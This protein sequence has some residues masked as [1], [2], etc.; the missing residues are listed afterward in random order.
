[1]TCTR[2]SDRSAARAC[3]CLCRL[4]LSMREILWRLCVM[5]SAA[6]GSAGK[7]EHPERCS[8]E[9]ARQVLSP[10]PDIFSIYQEGL[11]FCARNQ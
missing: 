9:D 4:G 7:R 11:P 10:E 1:V 5:A 2:C 8:M 3:L 6:A